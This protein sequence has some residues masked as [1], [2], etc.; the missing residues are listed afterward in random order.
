[1]TSKDEKIQAL[2]DKIKNMTPCDLTG[3]KCN[4]EMCSNCLS[5]INSKQREC[6]LF[7]KNEMDEVIKIIL[8]IHANQTY[9]CNYL[10]FDGPFSR[11][12][13]T[14]KLVWSNQDYHIIFIDCGIRL[15]LNEK[16]ISRIAIL[17]SILNQENGYDKPITLNYLHNDMYVMEGPKLYITKLP[18]ASLLFNVPMDDDK[19]KLFQGLNN[20][21]G[22]LM[23]KYYK[24]DN[25]EEAIFNQIY[26]C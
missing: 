17:D 22:T 25:V 21:N 24:Y 1:M 7:G 19:I 18:L 11:V 13:D 5:L 9:I 20:S 8:G 10:K 6:K 12:S 26:Y 15:I 23:Q 16:M 14:S 2:Y 3:C 4:L